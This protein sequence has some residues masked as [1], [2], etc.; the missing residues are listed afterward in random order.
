MFFD[1]KRSKEIGG[2]LNIKIVV[3]IN[4]IKVN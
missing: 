4:I 1:L 3:H 2:C